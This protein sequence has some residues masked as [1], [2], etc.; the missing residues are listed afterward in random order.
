MLWCLPLA[1]QD[2]KRE[3]ENKSMI[4]K[5]AEAL[6][7]KIREEFH[8][9]LKAQLHKNNL[10]VF[11]FVENSEEAKK[12]GIGRTMSDIIITELKKTG[13]F[14]IVDRENLEKVM[15]EMA[16][17]LSGMT[18]EDSA[19]EIGQLVSANL[20][21]TGSVGLVGQNYMVN[22]KLTAIETGEIILSERVEFPKDK[23]NSMAIVMLL[24]PKA[25][26]V[27][28]LRSALIPGWGQFYNDNNFRGS[29][30]LGLGL[31]AAGGAIASKIISDDFVRRG[32]V[33]RDTYDAWPQWDQT[34]VTSNQ[35]VSINAF[36]DLEKAYTNAEI[37][38]TWITAS[39]IG[40]GVVWFSAVLD[41]VISAAVRNAKIK[42]AQEVL[43]YSDKRGD[44]AFVMMPIFDFRARFAGINLAWKY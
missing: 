41:G 36:S 31:A 22:I 42:K 37:A 28:A 5:G 18:S 13:E 8:L 23:L 34:A 24:K 40:Y 11:P 12:N 20:F 33:F 44:G 6:A 32:D 10:A 30:Y 26:I 43:A 15:K 7:N 25:P 2:K 16:F 21:L 17:G 3:N 35:S 38:A 27:A 4:T 1:G 19:N 9:K 14:D 39:L 29:L